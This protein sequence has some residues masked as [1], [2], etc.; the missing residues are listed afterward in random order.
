MNTLVKLA[1]IHAYIKSFIL[2]KTH[3]HLNG[4]PPHLIIRLNINKPSA[5]SQPSKSNPDIFN[6]GRTSRACVRCTVKGCNR[7]RADG[8]Q[9][10]RSPPESGR[11]TGMCPADPDSRFGFR[12]R[13]AMHKWFYLIFDLPT[14]AESFFFLF[15]FALC[16]RGTRNVV[17]RLGGADCSLHLLCLDWRP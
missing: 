17:L 16:L 15:F 1:P 3:L 7:V 4:P 14:G 9:R 2:G 12:E 10:D 6:K 5:H 8:P 11:S 13:V